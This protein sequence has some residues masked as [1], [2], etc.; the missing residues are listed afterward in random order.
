MSILKSNYEISIW[1]DVFVNCELTEEKLCVIGTHDMSS[2]FRALEPQLKSLLNGSNTFTFKMHRFIIDPITGEKEENP[3]VGQ[4]VNE[5]KIKVNDDGKWYDLFIK[6]IKQDSNNSTYTY[7]AE[8]VHISELSKLGYDVTLD[9]QLM[10][11]LGTAKEL[12]ES[13]LE[14]DGSGIGALGW[15]VESEDLPEYH[16]DILIKCAATI[17]INAATVYAFYSCC[18]EQP[19]HFQYLNF[20]RQ[21]TNSDLD[22]DGVIRKT[23]SNYWFELPD[24]NGFQK[25]T[26][27]ASAFYG[28][29]FPTGWTP[30]ETTKYKAERK[31]YT[32]LS[33][34]NPVLNRY[35]WRGNIANTYYAT[36]SESEYITP[37]LV[38]NYVSNSTF[39]STSGWKGS[40]LTI[41]GKKLPDDCRDYFG[42]CEAVAITVDDE[43]K[44]KELQTDYWLKGLSPDGLTFSRALKFTSKQVGNDAITRCLINTGFRDNRRLIKNMAKG[45]QFVLLCETLGEPMILN[46]DIGKLV[47]D[48]EH[49]CYCGFGD[50]EE[51]DSV[52][53][54]TFNGAGSVD[55][56]GKRQTYWIGSVNDSFAMT[57]EEF[58]KSNLSIVIRYSNTKPE[59]PVYFT[60]FEIYPYIPVSDTD[61]TPMLPQLDN[62]DLE[63]RVVTHYKAYNDNNSVKDILDPT[64]YVYI[65]DSTTPPT[66]PEMETTERVRSLSTKQSNYFNNIQSLCE[67]F[68]CW[69]EF[70]IQHDSTGNITSKT[71]RLHQFVGQDNF[72][73]IRYGINLKNV[74][75]TIDSKSIVSRLIVADNVNE[76]A[77]NGF[78][79]IGRAPM[80]FTGENVIYDFSYFVNNGLLNKDFLDS[81]LY[82]DVQ[83]LTSTPEKEVWERIDVEDINQYYSKLHIFNKEIARQSEIVS[84]YSNSLVEANAYY[85]RVEAGSQQSQEQLIEL[86]EEFREI[87][88]FSYQEINSEARRETIRNSSKLSGLLASI[89]DLL[90]TKKEYETNL[91]KAIA[92]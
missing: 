46:V 89:S 41:P 20:G 49:E 6:N 51:G 57:E 67:K 75:R 25:V 76:F 63:G 48:Q 45:K 70:D 83:L 36:Y 14:V 31:V 11:N 53:Y 64:K 7:T 15:K 5:T 52:S 84:N 90:I 50:E 13:I 74:N 60:T 29:W 16:E 21:I 35:V 37:N 10:N 4:L 81:V 43:G 40:A 42:E 24:S 91:P 87:A 72:V 69:A 1:Q 18:S 54:V 68:E 47:Y 19:H 55:V 17:G 30:T 77:K 22:A 79:S 66:W 12:A 34:Y 3:F 86:T 23:D 61:P 2:P 59:Q 62:L 82:G 85:Q 33:Y 73:G 8:D 58:L 88:Q 26:N 44:I 9:D 28:M 27:P 56:N 65:Y 78:C 32:Q 92:D 38:D 71:L 39:S 80:N